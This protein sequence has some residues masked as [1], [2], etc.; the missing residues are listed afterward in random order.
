MLNESAWFWESGNRTITEDGRHVY[1]QKR[2]ELCPQDSGAIVYDVYFG[3][4]WRDAKKHFSKNGYTGK[5]LIIEGYNECGNA[6]VHRVVI[7]G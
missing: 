3:A 4:N 2:F 6:V 7:K 1:K 5:H